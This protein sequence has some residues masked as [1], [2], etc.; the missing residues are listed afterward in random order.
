MGI[1]DHSDEF[2]ESAGANPV[3]GAPKEDAISSDITV[4]YKYMLR[5]HANPQKQ[6]L[7]YEALLNN[8]ALSKDDARYSNGY[9]N[10]SLADEFAGKGGVFRAVI[11]G[12]S[13]PYSGRAV[14]TPNADLKF[15]ECAIPASMA[16]DIFRPT[17][18]DQLTAEGKSIEEIDAWMAQYRIP[19][20][21]ISPATKK[22][23]EDRISTRRVA[24]CR[25][26]SLHQSSFQ[27]FRPRI[28]HGATIENNPLICKAY[29]ADHD[30]DEMSCYGFNQEHIIPIL[31]RSIDATLPVNTRLPR[32]LETLSILPTKD[33]L[34]GI[35]SILEQR[36]K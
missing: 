18:L 25:Q 35:L 5:Q 27:S 6:Q 22:D 20:H 10:K 33:S 21:E 12:G 14:I 4:A 1:A 8:N 9:R 2:V 26:P 28:S 32:H 3:A 17:L 36:S 30:G 15:G 16:V 34:F 23:L 7:A 29:N 31:D 24:L 13:I 19:Q 11:S